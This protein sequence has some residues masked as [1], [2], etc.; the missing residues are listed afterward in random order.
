MVENNQTKECTQGERKG[1]NEKENGE[2]GER[3]KVV[4]ERRKREMRKE[5]MRNTNPKSTW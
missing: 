1:R 3:E 2:R 5:G 4:I